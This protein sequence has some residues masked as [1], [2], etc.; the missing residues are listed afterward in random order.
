MNDIAQ[1]WALQISIEYL[2]PANRDSLARGHW[3]F[4]S[5]HHER[6]GS[7]LS[8]SVMHSKESWPKTVFWLL[9]VVYRGI[10]KSYFEAH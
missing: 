10:S 4:L 7:K 6:G 3:I 9:F 8:A 5:M 2:P 1:I